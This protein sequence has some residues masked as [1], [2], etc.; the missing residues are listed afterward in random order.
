MT[1]GSEH[2]VE[3]DAGR[4]R[5][6]SD[7]DPRRHGDDIMRPRPRR[8]E[9][10]AQRRMDGFRPELQAR[11]AAARLQPRQLRLIGVAMDRVLVV[12]VLQ[13][14]AERIGGDLR[15]HRP[16]LDQRDMDAGAGQ[17]GAHA[18]HQPFERVLGGRIGA[19]PFDGH[20][21]EDR[22]AVDDAAMALRAH[23]GKHAPGQFVPAEEVGLEL[24]A[25]RR[26]SERSS[27]APG[28]A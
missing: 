3:Q 22:R 16:G 14:P 5:F 25:Q 20:Q 4:S 6:S 1:C 15:L 23:D 26:R 27:T 28:W 17:F 18:E 10:V 13:E 24:F 7:A 21:A 19:A 9:G 12:D 2:P 8:Q 11:D